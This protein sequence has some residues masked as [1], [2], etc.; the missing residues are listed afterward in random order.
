MFAILENSA[1]PLCSAHMHAFAIVIFCFQEKNKISLNLLIYLLASLFNT[2]L[3]A[4]LLNF[5]VVYM[6]TECGLYILILRATNKITNCLLSFYREMFEIN[7]A[8]KNILNI[9]K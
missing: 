8:L 5:I 3:Q 2:D 7:N 1:S 9:S 4:K 6:Y